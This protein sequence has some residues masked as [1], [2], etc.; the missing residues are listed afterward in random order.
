[1]EKTTFL[2]LR[3]HVLVHILFI[4]FTIFNI[5][6]GPF[7]K[8]HTMEIGFL[9]D[10]RICSFKQKLWEKRIVQSEESKTREESINPLFSFVQYFSVS[11]IFSMPYISLHVCIK[12]SSSP[13]IECTT[14]ISKRAR[15]ELSWFQKGQCRKKNEILPLTERLHIKILPVSGCH[16]TKKCTDENISQ[17]T[18]SGETDCM[19]NKYLCFI[20]FETSIVWTS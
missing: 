1:M 9:F 4:T 10:C 5:R 16:E 8:L 15:E 20:L 14:L 12:N 11:F 19:A 7:Q 18:A 3:P 6:I 13:M 17:W 2:S